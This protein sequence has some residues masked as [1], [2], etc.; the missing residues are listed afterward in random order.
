MDRTTYIV[1]GL[2]GLL[3][4]VWYIYIGS[5]APPPP[6]PVPAPPPEQEQTPEPTPPPAP[7]PT[8]VP[9]PAPPQPESE[10]FPRPEEHPPAELARIRDSQKVELA[11]DLERGGIA[12]ARLMQYT[13]YAER[14]EPGPQVELGNWRFPL[15]SMVGAGET[16]EQR[17]IEHDSAGLVLESRQSS[18]LVV[19]EQWRFPEGSEYLLDYTVSL[20][21]D[22]GEKL[23]LTDLMVAGG[24]LRAEQEGGGGPRM[25]RMGMMDL[26]VDFLPAGQN[27]PDRFNL[28][29][30]RRMS[31][32][33]RAEL[34]RTP[35]AW[36]AVHNKYFLFFIRP[37]PTA[38]PGLMI[39]HVEGGDDEDGNHGDDWV[40][41]GMWLSDLGLEP[42]QQAEW[43]FQV[44]AG[45]KEYYRLRQL[46]QGVTSVLGMD[47]F[48]FGRARWMGGLSSLIL[49][50]LLGLRGLGLSFGLAI[51]VVTVIVKILFWPLTHKSAV[52]MRKMQKLQPLVK[53]LREKHKSEPQVMNQKIMALYRE[54]KANPLGGCLPMLLQIPVFLALFNTLR[55]AIELRQ[56]SF[57]W[58][59]DLAQ[60]DT[61]GFMPFGLP[62]RPLA[63]L[64]GGSMMLQHKL[65]PT[66]ADPAQSKMMMFMSLFFIFIFYSM[67]A[68][69]TL[70][71]TINQVLTIFQH[72]L[73]RR[74]E[75]SKQNAS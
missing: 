5:V 75:K 41:G 25:Q 55:S 3:L 46:G 50:S 53:E 47:F 21:N 38:M 33:D 65:T 72:G 44:Y 1:V 34:A 7:T 29:D 61:L 52:S 8:A 32:A 31:P 4:L 45:P 28:R 40:Y 39:G 17:V 49:R 14:G 63:L 66:T 56:S 9:R 58:V 48:F 74:M 62:I 27:H 30:I 2:C 59:Y 10:L 51:V 64:M 13:E 60:P 68:G 11:M 57:L 73:L 19:T 69:L 43:K 54:H 71:W 26:G 12:R 42:G 18:G 70:Y 20:S 16:V 67:P 15:A 6:E 37:H 24:G 35:A 22:T 36:F 23:A